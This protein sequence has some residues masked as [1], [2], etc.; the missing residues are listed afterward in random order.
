MN[1]EKLKILAGVLS[2]MAIGAVAGIMS[3]MIS[4]QTAQ[5]KL[6]QE[7]SRLKKEIGESMN[8]RMEGLVNSYEQTIHETIKAL[9]ENAKSKRQRANED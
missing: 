3:A 7:T 2:G 1:T 5:K 9:K 8:K 4:G 6:E